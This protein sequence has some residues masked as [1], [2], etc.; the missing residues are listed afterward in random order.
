MEEKNEELEQEALTPEI[1]DPEDGAGEVLIPTTVMDEEE[2]IAAFEKLADIKEGYSPKDAVT[3]MRKAGFNNAAALAAFFLEPNVLEDF[4]DYCIADKIGINMPVIMQQLADAC[5]GGSS[6][7]LK[8]LMIMLN[9]LKP[10]AENHLTV[11]FNKMADA[12]LLQRAGSIIRDIEAAK[13]EAEE[14]I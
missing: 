13:N 5:K 1:V 9:K 14:E 2:K 8:M 11:Q 3:R 4:V 12:D 7:H 10:K 6:S